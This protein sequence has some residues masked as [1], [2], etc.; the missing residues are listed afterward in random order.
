MWWSFKM[1]L[2]HSSKKKKDSVKCL[3]NRILPETQ[4]GRWM[5]PFVSPSYFYLN[6]LAPWCIYQ[7]NS[8]ILNC[9]SRGAWPAHFVIFYLSCTVSP[10]NNGT[11]HYIT[12]LLGIHVIQSDIQSGSDTPPFLTIIGRTIPS[13]S[14]VGLKEERCCIRDGA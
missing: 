12:H 14:Q 9:G 4:G 1:N 13:K 11:L 5:L 7:P 3:S 10:A 2:S 8:F 6:C